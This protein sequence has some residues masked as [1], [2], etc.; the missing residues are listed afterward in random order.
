MDRSRT[1]R[2]RNLGQTWAAEPRRRRASGP[3]PSPIT[4]LRRISRL[5][6]PSTWLKNAVF[7]IPRA[8]S[9]LTAQ[10]R[11]RAN[12]H[13]ILRG[14]AHVEVV[15]WNIKRERAPLPKRV[16]DRAV[17]ND[18]GEGNLGLPD[19]RVRNAEQPDRSDSRRDF[20]AGLQPHAQGR[21]ERLIDGNSL[22]TGIDLAQRR[23]SVT[24]IEARERTQRDP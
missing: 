8:G 6:L 1:S 24:E 18:V 21:R 17:V 7:F 9:A 3:R 23:P 15:V 20:V 13:D 2:S 16:T 10:S 14:R 22:C 4:L 19:R 11:E 12:A 5:E